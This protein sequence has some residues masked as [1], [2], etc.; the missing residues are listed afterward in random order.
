M[1]C[2]S[3]SGYFIVFFGVHSELKTKTLYIIHERAMF[4]FSQKYQGV[5][6][7]LCPRKWKK[8]GWGRAVG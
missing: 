7:S 8:M 1:F 2:R 5:Y 6:F 4:H 3:F